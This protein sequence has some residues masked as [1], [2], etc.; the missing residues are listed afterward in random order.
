VRPFKYVRVERVPE[1]LEALGST[2]QAKLLAGG[3]NLVDLMRL[4]VEQPDVLVD[5]N[6][7]G[8]D[9]IDDTQDGGLSIGAGVRNSD[10]AADPRVRLR[11]PMLAEALLA[12]ASGQLRN[13]ATVGGNLMQRTRCV[14][15]Q[16][17]SKPCN[18]RRP[19]SGCPAREG[20]H[21]N[22]A[23]LG[24][25]EACI[26]THPSDMAVALAA[27]DATVHV[28]GPGGARTIPLTRF[29][30]LPGDHPERD[31]V[32]ERDELV[33]AVT[34]PPLAI[35]AP[36]TTYRK[37]R[38]RASFAFALVSIAAALDARGGTIR[39]ARIALGGVAHRP[40]RATRAEGVLR[41]SAATVQTIE[42]A[43]TA[44]LERAAPLRDNAYK[45]ELARN[46]MVDVLQ[47]LVGR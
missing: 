44:E 9:R 7:I 45:V 13:L 20:E 10:L 47:E 22:L 34:L 37:V 16:D 27:L 2:P 40:W 26:A 35:P 39:E 21:R 12:G 4:D 1:A 15:F 38:E 33:V 14:Y 8:F 41:G 24:H 6:G 19:G 17:V 25:S 30:R 42:A 46:L 32:L 43:I 5:V 36:Y 29:Y 31:T 28:E 23:I 18:K 11:F 3:T